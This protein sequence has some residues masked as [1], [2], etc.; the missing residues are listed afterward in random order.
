GREAAREA[1]VE[2]AKAVGV[3]FDPQAADRLVDDLRMVRVQQ[4]DNRF[5]NREGP[6]VEPVHLQVVCKSLWGMT[7]DDPKRISVDDIN[8]LAG[9]TGLVGV[10]GV[11]A[12]Y[13]AGRVADASREGRVSERRVRDWF[14]KQLI[15]P[16]RAR[17]QVLRGE[18]AA[19]G[20]NAPCLEIL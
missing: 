14:E 17:K 1:I 13:Y 19:A 9:E 2:P 3:T 16:L 20:L 12:G 7:R 15:T 5:V 18:E 8:K 4:P 11:L 10:D 6:Y